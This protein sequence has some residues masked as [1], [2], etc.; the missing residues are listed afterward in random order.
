M[1][2][3]PCTAGRIVDGRLSWLKRVN[4]ASS[5]SA[6]AIAATTVPRPPPR[7][8]PPST[9]AV[10]AM[11]SRP[12]PTWAVTPA[13]PPMRIAATVARKPERRKARVR[14]HHTEPP[15]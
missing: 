4:S 2:I 5:V 9:T 1:M 14:T 7:T 8:T 13:Y 12:C 6:P 11:N 15:A 3:T 10:I